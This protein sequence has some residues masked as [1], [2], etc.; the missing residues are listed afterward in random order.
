VLD[1]RFGIG[2]Y[3][4]DDYCRRALAAGF[5]AVITLDVFIHHV[6][7]ATFRASSVDFASIMRTNERKFKEKWEQQM[8]EDSADVT[9]TFVLKAGPNGGLLLERAVAPRP[10]PARVQPVMSLCMIVRDNAKTIGPAL[11]SIRPFVDEMIAV[12]TGSTDETP[13]VCERL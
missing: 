3:E 12:D 10:P 13:Q 8:A 4:D 1:E 9:P 6:G 7:G 2:C 11:E 5:R